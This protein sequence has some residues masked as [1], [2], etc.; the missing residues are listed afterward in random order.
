MRIFWILRMT[1]PGIIVPISN[2]RHYRQMAPVASPVKRPQCP[3][4]LPRA[5]GP[6]AAG[7]LSGLQMGTAKD[8]D[9]SHR[10]WPLT[11]TA[12]PER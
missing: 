4:L 1:V 2:I 9:I 5:L 7:S 12:G 11:V 10:M 8:H 6:P 3:V